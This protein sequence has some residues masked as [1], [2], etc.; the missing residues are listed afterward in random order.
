MRYKTQLDEDH[1]KSFIKHIFR[2]TIPIRPH[3]AD[4]VRG[5]IQAKKEQHGWRTAANVFC[6]G[7]RRETTVLDLVLS[8]LA[9]HSP[10]YIHDFLYN[11]GPGHGEVA[12]AKDGYPTIEIYYHPLQIRCV[13]CGTVEPKHYSY[14]YMRPVFPTGVIA[15]SEE[16]FERFHSLA[17][18]D[19][20]NGIHSEYPLPFT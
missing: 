7:C 17:K 9:F 18:A 13:Q 2:S 4:F 20:A 11:N 8:G 1:A 19:V 16:M 5:I 15:I 14:F 10:Q 12:F 3:E 6:S